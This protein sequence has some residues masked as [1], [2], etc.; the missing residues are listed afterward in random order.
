MPFKKGKTKTGGKVAGTKN[1]KT[2]ESI[3]RVEYVLSLLEPKLKD[4]IKKLEPVE[5]VKLW[6]DL[7]EYVRPK[8]SRTELAPGEG[9]DM[10]INITRTVI[11]KKV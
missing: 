2:I 6:N 8:L 3:K 5:R 7:Q 1:K 4:D 11:S 10:A 9:M